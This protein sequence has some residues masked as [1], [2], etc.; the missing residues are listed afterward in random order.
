MLQA[1]A[2]RKWLFAARV[3]LGA[4]PHGDHRRLRLLGHRQSR[5][6]L[7]CQPHYWAQG[8]CGRECCPGCSVQKL[9]EGR[10]TVEERGDGRRS[11]KI[12]PRQNAAQFNQP[13]DRGLFPNLPA[14]ATCASGRHNRSYVCGIV[15][16]WSCCDAACTHV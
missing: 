10:G 9:G 16:P 12:A 1:C 14:F 7:L 15:L 13:H 8:R 11:F 3:P 5:R 4:A 6:L 2:L